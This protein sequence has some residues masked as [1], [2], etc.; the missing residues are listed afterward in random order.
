MPKLLPAKKIEDRR[1]QFRHAAGLGPAP[2]GKRSLGWSDK[3]AV[4]AWLARMKVAMDPI[5]T[6]IP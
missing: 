3:I 4:R 2:D 1:L 6:W 5:S